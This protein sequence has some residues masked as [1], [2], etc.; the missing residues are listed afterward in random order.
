MPSGTP[1]SARST[2]NSRQHPPTR[3]HP[4]TRQHP[5]TPFNTLQHSNTLTPSRHAHLCALNSLLSD[6]SC[7]VARGKSFNIT[8]GEPAREAIE[9]WSELLRVCRPDW[10]PLTRS[11]EFIWRSLAV[12]SQGLFAFF[13]GNVPA[14]R[15][16]FW[17]LTLA[18]VGFATTTITLDI[19]ESR[20]C[21]GYKPRFTYRGSFDDIKRRSAKVPA[22]STS[23]WT[24]FRAHLSCVSPCTRRG[25]CSTWCPC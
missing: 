4:H 15:N 24:I 17:N 10:A 18:S 3:Q 25:V 8:N 14:R 1:T 9:T 11:P 12:L 5:P 7:G 21:I 13:A 2:N 16:P 19:S 20:K 22:T 6:T 23:F